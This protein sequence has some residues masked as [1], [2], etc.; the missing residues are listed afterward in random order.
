[1]RV[2]LW[3]TRGLHRNVRLKCLIGGS[4]RV[5]D[6]RHVWALVC[7]L[8][9]HGEW[10]RGVEFT[11]R[12]DCAGEAIC[13]S[14]CGVGAVFALFSGHL[15]EALQQCIDAARVTWIVSLR[16]GVYGAVDDI[17]VLEEIA[18]FVV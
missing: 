9:V 5:L 8:E 10:R 13:N 3:T 14:V 18:S 2:G 4:A 17:N 16:T 11:C 6:P 12:G 1:M 15:I 7:Q